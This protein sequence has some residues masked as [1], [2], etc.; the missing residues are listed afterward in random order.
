MYVRPRAQPGVSQYVRPQRTTYSSAVAK[1]RTVCGLEI[2]SSSDLPVSTTVGF[3]FNCRRRLVQPLRQDVT[4]VKGGI[5]ERGWG[6]TDEV[7]H[8]RA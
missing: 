8:W 3:L 4:Q 1:N 2:P 5:G 6:G 7:K